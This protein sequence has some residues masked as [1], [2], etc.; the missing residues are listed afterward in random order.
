[1]KIKK[2]EKINKK[3]IF[4]KS[5]NMGVQNSAVGAA[6]AAGVSAGPIGW[7][8]LG[9]AGAALITRTVVKG[10]CRCNCMCDQHMAAAQG[11]GNN[12]I[13]LAL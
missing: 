4:E 5:N 1:M 12:V 3:G 11:Y 7:V 8:F 13:T 2:I 9:F 10:G 6:V